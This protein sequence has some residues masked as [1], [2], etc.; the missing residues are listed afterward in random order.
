M[1][2]RGGVVGLIN[3]PMFQRFNNTVKDLVIFQNQSKGVGFF[4]TNYSYMTVFFRNAA[5]LANLLLKASRF[6]DGNKSFD[7]L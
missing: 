2:V 7:F 4:Y 1:F 5:Y 3:Y 6:S